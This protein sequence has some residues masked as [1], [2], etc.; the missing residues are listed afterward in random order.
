MNNTTT[1]TVTRECGN[2]WCGYLYPGQTVQIERVI[3]NTA[4]R[5]MRAEVWHPHTLTVRVPVGS[6]SGLR[7]A[8]AAGQVEMFYWTPGQ[9]C[10]KEFTETP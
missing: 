5:R 8:V 2:Q 3:V 7:E 10:Y 1:F 4:T 9:T 6:I